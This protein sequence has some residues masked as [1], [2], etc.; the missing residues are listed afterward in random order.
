M[1]EYSGDN[2]TGYVQPDS[3]EQKL[4]VC[5]GKEEA[6]GQC[7]LSTE[8]AGLEALTMNRPDMDAEVFENLLLKS[9]QTPG[10]A[11]L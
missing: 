7:S 11:Y 10:K 1:P 9:A 2:E 8:E 4:S 6:G 3:S 5:E